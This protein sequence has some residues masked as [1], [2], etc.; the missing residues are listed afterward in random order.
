MKIFIY[1]SAL[2]LLFSTTAISGTL[3]IQSMSDPTLVAPIETVEVFV[4]RASLE[5]SVDNR[6][7]ASALVKYHALSWYTT[8]L[9]HTLDLTAGFAFG[10]NIASLGVEYSVAYDTQTSWTP[11]A[12]AALEYVAPVSNFSNNDVFMTPGVG[13]SYSINETISAF[14]E[15][16]YSFNASN[17]FTRVGGLAEVGLDVA[18]N[19]NFSVIPSVSRT[20]DVGTSETTFALTTVF[21]F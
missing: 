21:R 5:F 19:R 1:A 6:G 2:T 18:V 4:P 3:S 20:F 13:L 17:G 15:V 7:N 11:Y 12:F 10:T 9:S 14:A 8:N 16:S